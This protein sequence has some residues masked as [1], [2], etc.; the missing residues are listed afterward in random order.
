MNLVL[1]QL[2]AGVFS[3]A[4]GIESVVVNVRHRKITAMV[5]W[6][7]NDLAKPQRANYD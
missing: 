6:A 3:L 5:L 4:G 2:S 7:N 1:L